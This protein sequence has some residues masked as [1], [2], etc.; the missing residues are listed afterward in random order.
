MVLKR[1]S[2]SSPRAS[3][4]R[5]GTLEA[6][7]GIGGGGNN[8]L[9]RISEIGVEGAKIIAVNDIP[10]TKSGKIAELA[11]RDLIHNKQ[12]NNQTALANPE[13]LDEYQNITELNF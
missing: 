12:I 8:T 4:S 3:G 7:G 1:A 6:A 5:P 9:D 2:I 10:R 13:C 11:V